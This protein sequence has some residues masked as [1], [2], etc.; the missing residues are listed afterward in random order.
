MFLKPI[1]RIIIIVLT[2]ALGYGLLRINLSSTF[3][4]VIKTIVWIIVLSNSYGLGCDLTNRRI[5]RKL[6]K[7]EREGRKKQK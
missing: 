6:E 5:K 7:E 4:I 2:V 1:E 3:K